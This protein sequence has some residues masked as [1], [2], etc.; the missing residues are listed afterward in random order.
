MSSRYIDAAFE[1]LARQGS[2]L[3]YKVI[4]TA[5]VQL[6]ILSCAT[7]NPD[8]VFSSTLS[9]AASENPNGPFRKAARGVY[10]LANSFDVSGISGSDECSFRIGMIQNSIG[11]SNPQAILYK[12][13]FLL[14]NAIALAG[15]RFIIGLGQHQAQFRLKP[16]L[17]H[18]LSAVPSVQ[19]PVPA[20]LDLVRAAAPLRQALEAREVMHVFMLSLTLFQESLNHA[21]CS[22]ILLCGVETQKRILLF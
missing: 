11:S 20:T 18:R 9:R 1:V 15:S 19:G 14:R 21:E 22:R 5:A 12:S 13:L 7:R 16:T 2:A 10:E 4:A 17:S 3:H 6:G 8:I